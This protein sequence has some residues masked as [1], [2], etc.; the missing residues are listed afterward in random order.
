MA[1]FY[2][3]NPP[4]T[5]P[6]LRHEGEPTAAI[7]HMQFDERRSDDVLHFHILFLICEKY[8]RLV[9]AVI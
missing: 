3:A 5:V 9:A 4:T 2:L 1:S 7:M 8:I 6:C